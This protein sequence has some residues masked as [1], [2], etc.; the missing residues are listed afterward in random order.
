MSLP[1]GTVTFLFTDV[2]RS[3]ELLGRLGAEGYARALAEHRALLREAF[4]DHGGVEVDAQGDAFFV[5]FARAGDA[6]SA[7]RWAQTALARGPISVRMGIHT[8]E[9]LA[10]DSGYV[11]MDVH[12]AA[13]I[14]AAGHG[15]QILLSRATRD[16]LPDADVVDLGDYRLKDL[17]RPE[18]IYQLGLEEHPPLKSLNRSTLPEAAHPLVGRREEQRELAEL[19]R[20]HRLVTITGPGGTGKTR[21]AI[22]LAAEL[23]DDYEGG[24]CFVQLASL[25][26]PGLVIPVALEA[27]NARDGA[28][29]IDRVCLLVLDNFEHVVDA[30]PAVA[31]LVARTPGATVLVTSRTPLHLSMEIEYPLDTL[32]HRAAVELFLDRARAVRRQAEPSAT[33]DE[34]C[35]RLD[36]LPLALELAAARLKLL[37]PPSLLARLE[38]RLPLLTRGPSDVPERQRTL[39]ATIQWSYGLLDDEMQRLLAALSVFSGSFDID[40]AE[41]VVG[42]D[43]DGLATLVDASLLKP[44]GD[45]RFLMLETIREFARGRLAD[46]DVS[47]L[48]RRHAA[49]FLQLAES[50]APELLGPEAAPWFDRLEHDSGNLRTV[51]DWCALV[52]PADLPRLTIAL[53]RFW[54]VRGRYE[55]GQIAIE[56]AIAGDASRAERALL[57]YQLGALVISR[58]ATARSRELFEEALELFRA[59]D[60]VDGEARALAALGHAA[61]DAGEWSHAIARYEAATELLRR[62][63]NRL[64]VGATLSDRA[65]VHLRSGDPQQALPLALEGLELQRE[66]GNQQGESLAL[67]TAGYAYAASGRR[68]E[69]REL[70]IE[71]AKKAHDLGY[72]HGLLFSLNGL[73]LVAY[74]GGDVARAAAIF[75]DAD[76]LRARIGIVHDP[77]EALVVDARCDAYAAAP[78][79]QHVDELDLDAAVAAAIADPQ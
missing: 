13:R 16:L 52:E 18:R 17:T 19:I 56:R 46:E 4:A 71:S 22:Q 65:T 29:G 23:Y 45:S 44:R 11:G 30:A 6:V 42:A 34:I 58:G 53:W 77:D 73:A 2:E 69:G 75:A 31:E 59:E 12:R 76:A 40:A 74:D 51:L 14:A 47:T 35:R 24:A 25:S 27:L 41:A 68:A 28:A 61:A 1:D 48:P 70:L 63:G 10:T 50:A 43:L 36:G 57:A 79:P 38:R 49:Y 60:D 21:L 67:A 72:L 26:D 54:L 20:A 78:Q 62:L 37:D 55:E 33:V 9:P 39:E 3:T 7:A 8:G 15:G 64:A 66:H 32:H 5:A